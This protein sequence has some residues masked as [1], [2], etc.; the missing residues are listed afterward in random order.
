M[1]REEAARLM[2]ALG[3]GWP[4]T[5]VTPDTIEVWFN[6][7]LQRTPFDVGLTVVTRLVETEEFFPTVARFRE[8]RRMVERRH[9]E[10][11]GPKHLVEGILPKGPQRRWAA[12]ARL[13]AAETPGTGTLEKPKLIP[14]DKRVHTGSVGSCEF[15]QERMRLS[16]DELAERL[17]AAG[18]E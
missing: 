14:L 6:S 15:C 7:A 13:I 8:V 10:N 16:D 2:A 11:D 4:N 18:L 17:H 9:A 1:T 5:K 12:V 3:S